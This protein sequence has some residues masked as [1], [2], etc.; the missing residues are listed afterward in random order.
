MNCAQDYVFV[1]K[2][3]FEHTRTNTVYE[4]REKT[5]EILLSNFELRSNGVYQIVLFITVRLSSQT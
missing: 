2:L 3:L 4:E 5:E 1:Y